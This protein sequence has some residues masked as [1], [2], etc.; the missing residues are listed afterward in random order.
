MLPAML[1]PLFYLREGEDDVQNATIL[2]TFGLCIVNQI[3]RKRLYSRTD[4]LGK[5]LVS[6]GKE[7]NRL[8]LLDLLTVS[9][10]GRRHIRLD[11]RL[12][13]I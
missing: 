7:G 4:H 3:R 2:N 10:L 9:P 1:H 13:G 11:E 5:D 6:R 12:F 8:P